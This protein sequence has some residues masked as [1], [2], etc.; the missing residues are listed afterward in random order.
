MVG[1][2][3]QHQHSIVDLVVVPVVLSK[4][5]SVVRLQPILTQLAHQVRSELQELVDMRVV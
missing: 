3:A 5:L 1:V 2:Q 4:L